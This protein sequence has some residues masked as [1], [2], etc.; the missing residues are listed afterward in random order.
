[1]LRRVLL[2]ECLVEQSGAR[3]LDGSPGGFFFLPANSTANASKL[4]VYLQGGGECRTAEDCTAWRGGAGPSS[5]EWPAER[6]VDS[7]SELTSSLRTNPDLHDWAKLFL[8]YCSADMHSGQRRTRDKALGG[9]FFAGHSILAASLQHLRNLSDYREPTV[10]FVSGSSAGGI[11]ALLHADFFA[12]HWSRASV[13][14]SP[15]AGF[16]Y[17]GVSSLPDWQASHQTPPHNLGFLASW[18]PYIDEGCAAATGGNM[19]A[20]TDAHLALPHIKTALFLRENLFDTAKLA[21]CGLDTRG[22]LTAMQNAYL[23]RWGLWMRQQLAVCGSAGGDRRLGLGSSALS[24]CGFFSPSCLDHADNLDWAMAPPVRGVS[25]HSALRAWLFEA[26]DLLRP[27]PRLVDDCGD[28]PCT[29]PAGGRCSHLPHPLTARCQS[30]LRTL[31]PNLQAKG[32]LCDTC[33]RRHASV[34]REHGCPKQG[35]PVVAWWCD[36]GEQP[37]GHHVCDLHAL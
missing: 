27:P 13:K 21:N 35:M 23:R 28:L 17:A 19:T 9:F 37:R 30:E 6:A 33:V 24:S 34:L 31:C 7:I 25:M 16:F 18:D 14:V 36:G 26:P 22:P 32:P 3:C 5:T 1:M 11:G 4:V 10:V 20:C 8:P 12:R 15:A 29:Q 2:P